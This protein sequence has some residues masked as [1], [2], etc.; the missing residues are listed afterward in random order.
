MP[1]VSPT[2]GSPAGA[3]LSRLVEVM[4]RLLAPAGC[5]W[6]REQTLD[7]LRPFLVEETYEV[8]DALARHDVAGHCEELG[9]LLMQVVFHAAIR[10]AEG[11]FD[12]D[13]VVAGITDKLIHRHPH[14][15]GSATGPGI[16]G[17]GPAPGPAITT[18]E[19]VLAQWE[20]IKA[21][22]KA[23]KGVKTDRVLAGVKPAPALARAQKISAK[24][25]KVGFDWPDWQG[26][27]A[28]VEEEVRE[29]D[30]AARGT[31]RAAMHHELGDLL[32]AV[33]NVARKLGVDAEQ[34][35]VDATRRFEQRFE[36]VE[37]RL[38]E[39][40][41]TPRTSNL[42]EMDA[43]WNEAKARFAKSTGAS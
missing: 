20:Q 36:H 31:D 14:V 29:I 32:F 27:L 18:S 22:E 35:L 13:A 3:S 5:P 42:E 39:R 38:I 11:A 9:D 30:E 41:K 17:T 2:D 7:T 25:A 19:Q 21:A 10:R 40:G 15:F 12:I 8:L 24:A 4:D 28:K 26:S 16:E 34:A 37:D 1:A 23:Q 43:L 33:V 6:D